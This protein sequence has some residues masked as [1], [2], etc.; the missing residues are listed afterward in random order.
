MTQLAAMQRENFALANHK[1]QHMQAHSAACHSKTQSSAA[2]A[3]SRQSQPLHAAGCCHSLLLLPSQLKSL[4]CFVDILNTICT[5]TPQ[6]E[7]KVL[8][9]LPVLSTVAL[10]CANYQAPATVTCPNGRVIRAGGAAKP[11]GELWVCC[12][13]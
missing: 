1:L 12:A 13:H 8:P 11:P 2:R 4:N 6:Q 3:Q 7:A 5:L 10:R 9:F